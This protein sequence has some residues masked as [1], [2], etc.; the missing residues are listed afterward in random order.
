[1]EQMCIKM[2]SSIDSA[3]T[4]FELLT[5]LFYCVTLFLQYFI[6]DCVSAASDLKKLLVAH[7][8]AENQVSVLGNFLFFL[9]LMFS[10]CQYFILIIH[11]LFDIAAFCVVQFVTTHLELNFI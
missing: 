9:L 2:V 8:N 4:T 11:F 6:M 3:H 7:S 10:S 5:V 1:M